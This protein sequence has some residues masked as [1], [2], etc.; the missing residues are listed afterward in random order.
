M[1][2]PVFTPEEKSLIRRLTTPAKV[3]EFLI[4]EIA[5]DNQDELDDQDETWR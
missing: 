2:R 5:Y 4:K 3:Q 1:F